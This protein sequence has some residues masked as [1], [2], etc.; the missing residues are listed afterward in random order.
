MKSK[1]STSKKSNIAPMG[2][3]NERNGMRPVKKSRSGKSKNH[4]SIYDEYDD[5]FDDIPIG[6]TEDDD[7][8]FEDDED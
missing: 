5:D 2:G 6:Y 3:N 4:L 7:D 1:N 8:N